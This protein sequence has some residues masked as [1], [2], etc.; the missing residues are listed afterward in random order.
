[1]KKSTLIRILILLATITVNACCASTPSGPVQP[2]VVYLPSPPMKCNHGLKRPTRPALL[3]PPATP[4][5]KDLDTDLAS[6]LD[7]MVQLEKH[8]IAVEKVCK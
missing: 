7:Y 5:C 1:M 4:D 3:C 6:M 2:K 8:A